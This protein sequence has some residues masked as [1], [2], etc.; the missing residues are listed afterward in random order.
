MHSQLSKVEGGT[1]QMS[2]T[3]KYL[4]MSN[5]VHPLGGCPMSADREQGVVDHRGQVYGYP[6]LFVLDGSI[7]PRP[8]GRNPSL[9]I[10]ALAERGA[11]LMSNGN[12]A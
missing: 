9:T 12:A 3:L 1:A 5:T 11:G 8:L 2:P 10:A 6:N 4:G 7:V